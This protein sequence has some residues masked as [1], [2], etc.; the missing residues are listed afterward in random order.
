MTDSDF[1][2]KQ[3][4]SLGEFWLP[5]ADGNTVT[6]VLQVDGPESNEVELHTIDY[7]N[8]ALALVRGIRLLRD[9]EEHGPIAAE[10]ELIL[11]MPWQ[12]DPCRLQPIA[13]RYRTGL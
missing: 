9:G 3:S 6:G 7:P 1:P 5:G 2:I 10:G 13:Y 4:N 12:I 11:Q 8:N